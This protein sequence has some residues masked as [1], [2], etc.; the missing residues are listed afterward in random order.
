[1]RLKIVAANWKMHTD[2]QEGITL[3]RDVLARCGTLEPGKLL[4][5]APPFTHL[6]TI[7]DLTASHQR[8]AVAAQNCHY[9]IKGAFTGEVS[10]AMI[11]SVGCRYVIIGHSERRMLF[12]ETEELILKKI[13][14]A[15]NAGLSVIYCC[16]EPLEIREQGKHEAY[17]A[18]QLSG[19]VLRLS[20]TMLS[21]IIIAY[22][23]VWAIGTGQNAT[24]AQAQQ[25]HT[26]IR[27]MIN[28]QY[29]NDAASGVSI[30]YGGSIKA[31]NAHALF[32]QPDVD[33]GLV[34]GASLNAEEFA[35]IFNSF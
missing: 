29:G 16:G 9:E 10:A 27:K 3:V 19:S 22:E 30:L 8:V 13:N 4:I 32:A 17:V 5:F 2:F 14:A 31:A 35:A 12:N 21:K 20:P 34:G 6:K 33:G 15:L 18:G 28:A 1:M 11:Q 24:A 23:P 7:A 25:M 26:F